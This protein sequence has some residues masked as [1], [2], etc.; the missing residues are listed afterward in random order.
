MVAERPSKTLDASLFTLFV[1]LLRVDIVNY[2]SS[3]D[4]KVSARKLAL[5]LRLVEE[6]LPVFK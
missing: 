2:S 5:D 6:F 4:Y 3:R 1:R